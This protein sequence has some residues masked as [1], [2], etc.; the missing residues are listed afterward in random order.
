[1]PTPETPTGIAISESGHRG[2][3]RWHAIRALSV[4]FAAEKA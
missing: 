1:L 2:E 4:V 3:Y